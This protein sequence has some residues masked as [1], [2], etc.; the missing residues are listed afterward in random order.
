MQNR[1]CPKVE[2]RG[3]VLGV[4]SNTDDMG[5]Y[6]R[7]PVLRDRNGVDMMKSRRSLTTGSTGSNTFV[8]NI[9]TDDGEQFVCKIA[10]KYKII[11]N[12]YVKLNDLKYEKVLA[13][14]QHEKQIYEIMY[15][16]VNDQITPF[17]MQR[18][19]ISSH[20]NSIC[21]ETNENA[22]S[23]SKYIRTHKPPL[24]EFKLIFFA[25]L[26]SIECFSRIGVRH[27]DLHPGNI[28]MFPVEKYDRPI[29]F[30]YVTR[31]GEI[32][33]YDLSG[34]RWI[35]VIYDFDRAFKFKRSKVVAKYSKHISSSP[36]LSR[37]REY[38]PDLDTSHL[39]TFKILAHLH[40]EAVKINLKNYVDF[41]SKY[42]LTKE[43]RN[44]MENL[45]KFHER[46][47]RRYH[48]PVEKN[49]RQ[50][51]IAHVVPKS[52]NL[53]LSL[54]PASNRP[55]PAHFSMKRIYM[56]SSLN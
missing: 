14:Q 39:N 27:N 45:H 22:I 1:G 20:R 25:I 24:K 48:L 2:E 19:M 41:L 56:P 4:T 5:R 32:H 46:L 43:Q 35:P 28:L 11:N 30:E 16:L 55:G 12:D 40:H 34:M 37:W 36:V 23:L 15:N 38:N 21:T 18:I 50:I 52:E 6:H 42:V 26:Y 13:G 33:R 49:G 53:L 8:W 17:V 31:G 29:I 54:L 7:Y 44:H 3:A 51:S 47:W 10:S 9:T